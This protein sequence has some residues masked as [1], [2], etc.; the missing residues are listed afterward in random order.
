M[1]NEMKTAEEQK[2][3]AFVDACWAFK[4]G[5]RATEPTAHEFH[6]NYAIAEVLA[7]QVHIEFQNQ[8]TRHLPKPGKAVA[9]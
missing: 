2:Y 4:R 7:R 8:Q 6:I 3:E 5:Q 9:A 1:A